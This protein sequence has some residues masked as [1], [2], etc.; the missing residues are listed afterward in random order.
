MFLQ[1]SCK[2]LSRASRKD[3]TDLDSWKKYAMPSKGTFTSVNFTY[4]L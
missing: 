3:M 4:S 2:E 1:S